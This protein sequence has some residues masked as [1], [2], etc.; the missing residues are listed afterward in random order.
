M[1]LEFPMLSV[2]IQALAAA[3]NTLLVSFERE[4]SSGDLANITTWL[5]IGCDCSKRFQLLTNACVFVAGF[6]FRCKVY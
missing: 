2:G 3:V 4:L 5:E 1:L 6:C